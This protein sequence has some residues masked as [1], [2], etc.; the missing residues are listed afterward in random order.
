MNYDKS[1]VVNAWSRGVQPFQCGGL[2]KFL[3]EPG[4][5]LETWMFADRDSMHVTI[6][7]AARSNLNCPPILVSQPGDPKGSGFFYNSTLPDS[8]CVD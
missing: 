3:V 5:H 1:L 8:L 2:T 4:G 7:L 6:L